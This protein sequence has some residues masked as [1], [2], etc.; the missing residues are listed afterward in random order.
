MIIILVA[1]I[2]FYG[3]GIGI[4]NKILNN[5]GADDISTA[6][7]AVSWPTTMLA[8]WICLATRSQ[9]KNRVS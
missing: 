5:M 3:A 6:L 9:R 8:L 4:T 2:G 7:G 1:A